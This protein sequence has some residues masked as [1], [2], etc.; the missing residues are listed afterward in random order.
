MNSGT[1]TIVVV[2]LLA[3]IAAGLFY[4]R[5]QSLSKRG[6]VAPK[7]ILAFLGAPGSGKGTLAKQA[8]NELNF[9]SLS[10]GDLCRAEVAS[11]SEKG[12]MIAE[13]MKGGLIPDTVMTEMVE[14]WLNANAGIK[15]IIVDGYPRT[16]DQA[17]MLADLL[18]TK[19]AEYVFGV[20]SLTITNEDEVVQRIANRVVCDKC[21]AVYSRTALKDATACPACGGTLITR[22]DDKEEIVRAR[23]AT[24][25]KNNAEIL[26]YYQEVGISVHV[27]NVSGVT[28]EEIFQEFKKILP[29]YA[30]KQEATA[31]CSCTNCSCAHD[32]DEAAATVAA[33]EEITQ[34][35]MSDAIQEEAPAQEAAART[36]EQLAPAVK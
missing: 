9:Q 4:S 35:V 33:T 8:V 29:A 28:P 27:L 22:E 10:T 12:K 5:R 15:P 25:N 1:R 21:K 18:K 16:K 19:F 30:P 26:A 32:H 6:A 20:V 31:G 36:L 2:G 7:T 17:V 24:F 11:G 13:Y 34:A 14:V 23:L 3:I